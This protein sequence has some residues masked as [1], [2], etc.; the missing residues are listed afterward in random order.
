VVGPGLTTAAIDLLARDARPRAWH[1][2]RLLDPSQTSRSPRTALGCAPIS[3]E[4]PCIRHRQSLGRK[5]ASAANYAP[6]HRYLIV[7]WR[8]VFPNRSSLI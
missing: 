3:L 6:P 7:S 2:K 5:Q 4:K 1:P 8:L